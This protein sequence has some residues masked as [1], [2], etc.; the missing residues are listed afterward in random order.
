MKA[1]IVGSGEMA[2]IRLKGL[3]EAGIETTVVSRSP[4]FAKRLELPD[5]VKVRPIQEIDNVDANLVFVCSAT[6][7]HERDLDAV[8]D[9]GVP[10]L[11]EKPIAAS[12][13]EA[14]ALARRAKA[15]GTP[16]YV[17][18]MR[19]F[20]AGFRQLHQYVADGKAGTLYHLRGAHYDRH[21]KGRD[22]IASS[23]GHFRDLLVHDI[24]IALWLTRQRVKECY[25]WGSVRISKDYADFEDCDVASIM[26]TF[27]DGLT[28]SIQST[29]AQPLGHDVR[30]EVVGSEGAFCTGIDDRTPLLDCEPRDPGLNVNPPPHFSVR[31]ADAFT[32]ETREFIDFATGKRV[33]FG[34]CTADEAISALE[35]AEACDRS[36]RT[37]RPVVL[38]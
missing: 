17:A 19:R 22:F 38:F 14:S 5:L 32:T 33:S 25:G 18:F 30:F 34:G 27:E 10:L 23:G 12:V 36:W 26:L 16:F 1:L 15:A 4:D 8:V 24:D 35:V 3:R 7:D 21:A 9:R 2:V 29:R 37:K 6:A 28:A 31:F 13:M 11:C 20:D